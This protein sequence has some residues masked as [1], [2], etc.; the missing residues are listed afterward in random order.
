[1]PAKKEVSLLPD[2][3]NPNS[4]GSRLLLWLTTVGRFI[5]V[6][7]ELIVISAFISRF[8]LDRKNSDLSETLRQQKAILESTADFEKE[9][10][11]LQQRLRVIKNFYS[12]RPDYSTKI[13]SLTESTPP[14]ILFNSLNFDLDDKSNITANLLATALNNETIQR[15][16]NNLASNPDIAVVDVKNIEK[17]TKENKF[18][19]NIFLVFKTKNSQT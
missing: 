12:L 10:S 18:S 15:F 5:I 19:I 16:I 4:L 2:A 13:T 6:F 7:T 9:Y 1:M 14:D 17:K 11:L 3:E 8:W